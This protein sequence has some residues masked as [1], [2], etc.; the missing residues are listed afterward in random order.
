MRKKVEYIGRKTKDLPWRVEVRKVSEEGKK[1][2]KQ[3][4][5]GSSDWETTRVITCTSLPKAP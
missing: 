1:K 2:R 3:E 4:E 5:E